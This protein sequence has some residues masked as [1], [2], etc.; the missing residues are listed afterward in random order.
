MAAENIPYPR[1]ARK[2]PLAAS[3][4]ATTGSGPDCNRGAPMRPTPRPRSANRGRQTIPGGASG[5]AVGLGRRGPTGPE[6]GRARV[7]ADGSHWK[8]S[9]MFSAPLKSQDTDTPKLIA[10]CVVKPSIVR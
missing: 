8:A 6:T 5:R 7:H 1:L 10:Q 9:S 2:L 3:P 4:D